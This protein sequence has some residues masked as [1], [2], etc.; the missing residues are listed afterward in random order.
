MPKSSL[1]LRWYLRFTLQCNDFFFKLFQTTNCSLFV[2]YFNSS[3]LQIS[4]MAKT[5]TPDANTNRTIG[6]TL[7]KLSKMTSSNITLKKNVNTWIKILKKWLKSTIMMWKLWEKNNVTYI[8]LLTTTH[9]TFE[10]G[11]FLQIESSRCTNPID[12]ITEINKNFACIRRSKEVYATV[13][14]RRIN[15]ISFYNSQLI[16]SYWHQYVFL[17]LA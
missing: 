13:V 7:S 10:N 12:I 8:L 15:D 16:K 17:P 6:Q 2:F 4:V 11:F 5:K 9:W 1:A 3:H 14:S